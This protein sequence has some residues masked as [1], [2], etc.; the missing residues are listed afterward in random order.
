MLCSI[1]YLYAIDLAIDTM[2]SI[3]VISGTRKVKESCASLSQIPKIKNYIGNII[4]QCTCIKLKHY[5]TNII[6]NKQIIGTLL[7]KI[8]VNYF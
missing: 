1:I 6:I 3:I 7:Q 8:Q 2:Y 5:G 4:A